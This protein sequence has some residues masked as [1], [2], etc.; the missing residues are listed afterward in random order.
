V[1]DE[2]RAP[3][4]VIGLGM[5]GAALA[6]AFLKEGHRTT[7]WN[8]SAGKADA[9]VEQGAVRAESITG[10]VAASEVLVICVVDYEALHSILDP[11]GG[12]LTGKVIINLTSGLPEDA[13][14][15]AT[16]AENSGAQYLDGTIMAIP[17]GIGL[18]QTLLF[19]SGSQ[20]TFEANQVTLRTLGGNS[21]FLSSDAGIAALYDLAL[22]SILWP[23]LSGALHGFA[24]L[25]SEKISATALLPFIEPWIM[26]AVLPTIQDSAQQVDAGAYGTDISTVS[27]S[28]MGLAKMVKASKAQGIRP[29]LMLPIK[30]FLEKRVADGYGADALAS[31]VEVIRNPE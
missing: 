19:Y 7:V 30:N 3:V 26:H 13:R 27:L 6:G 17:P 25:G 31:M 2:D 18:P 12:E 20:S 1:V 23:A 11:V 28:A 24:L 14:K 10:A 21:V 29:D 8:R 9:L 4:T 5:M 16:W 15:T 22:L